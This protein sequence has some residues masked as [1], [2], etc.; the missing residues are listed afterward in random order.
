MGRIDTLNTSQSSA[1]AA[2]QARLDE[3][4]GADEDR[5]ATLESASLLASARLEGLEARLANADDTVAERVEVLESRFDKEAKRAEER[6]KAT[7]KAIRKGLAGLADRLT[8]NEQA[9][10]ESG[11]ALRRAIERLGAAVIEADTRIAEMPL[12]APDGGYVAFVPTGDGYRLRPLEGVVPAVG[13]LLDLGE[14]GGQLRVTR[15][16]T[17]PLP[18]DRRACAYLERV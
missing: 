14:A 3:V 15:I 17:S 13:D 6:G 10:V 7:E 9:Y 16:A 11:Q 18:L 5:L 8:G 1:L 2:V 12:D 4:G